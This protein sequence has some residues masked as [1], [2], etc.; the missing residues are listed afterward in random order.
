MEQIISPR[1][2][3]IFAGAGGLS[4]GLQMAGWKTIA[5]IEIDRSAV[6]TYRQ[7]FPDVSVIAADACTVDFSELRGVD[8]VAGG[9]PCQ[10]F[11]VAGKQLSE[12]DPR[13]MVPQFIRAVKEV[14]PKAFL[15]ENVPGLVTLRHRHYIS[16]AVKQLEEQGYTVHLKVLDAANYGVPQHRERVFLVGI[17]KGISFAFPVPTHGPGTSRPFVTVREALDAAP[18]DRINTAKVVYARKPVLRPSPWAGML[19][20]GQGRP[21]DLDAPSLTIPASA[22]GN[23]THIIDP[24]RVLFDYHAHL[25]SG[26]KPKVGEVMGVRRLTARESARLQSFPDNFSFLGPKTKHY[27]LIGNAVPPLLAKAVGWAILEALSLS[28]EVNGQYAGTPAFQ[29]TLL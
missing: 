16:W 29:Y 17:P 12:A 5:A 4:L 10:P 13:D 26:G 19:V 27:H 8:L 6:A 18:K 20:N 28:Q 24:D 14:H 7:N 25:T 2:V 15:M 23:R 3:D 9:P 22:G 21:L 1:T 11:S